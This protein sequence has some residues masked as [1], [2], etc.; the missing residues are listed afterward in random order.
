L[1]HIVAEDQEGAI[2]KVILSHQT[3][4]NADCMKSIVRLW[5]DDFK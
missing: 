4:Q 3:K 2:F 1:I 5:F